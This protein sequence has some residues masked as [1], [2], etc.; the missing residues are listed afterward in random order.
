MAHMRDPPDD[1]HFHRRTLI[2]QAESLVRAYRLRNEPEHG[3]NT[4]QRKQ[5]AAN[6]VSKAERL[7]REMESMIW[8]E[9]RQSA[10]LRAQAKARIGAA[11]QHD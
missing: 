9:D 11:S 8:P 3:M 10:N 4:T 1:T 5:W 6:V 2:E 7:A